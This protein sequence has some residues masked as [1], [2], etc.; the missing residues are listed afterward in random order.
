MYRCQK[1]R[2]CVPMSGICNGVVQCP[3][4]DDELFCNF[5]CPENCTCS[6]T[7]YDCSGVVSHSLSSLHPS[8][9]HLDNSKSGLLD[10]PE[11][12]GL[13]PFLTNLILYS[14]NI[15]N[16]TL[17]QFSSTNN[18]LQLDLSLN[19]IAQILKGTF[20]GLTNLLVL[21][22]TGNPIAT[23]EAATFVGL[24][25]LPRLDLSGAADKS[26]PSQAIPRLWQSPTHWYVT[27]RNN[28]YREWVS[29]RCQT[30]ESVK[31]VKQ[32]NSELCW[33]RIYSSG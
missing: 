20:E 23:I 10:V 12:I 30:T 27:Q 17:G 16:L 3:D 18:L 19:D 2:V 5:Y 4:R 29:V 1:S 28:Q 26:N 9:R 11:S 33:R 31:S 22:I 6:D 25:S 32:C 13:A 21:K 7:S 24:E 14:N 15:R 8:V